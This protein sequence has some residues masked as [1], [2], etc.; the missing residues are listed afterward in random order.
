MKYTSTILF[1]G[2]GLMDCAI[3]AS[4]GRIVTAVEWDNKVAE[5]YAYNF[6]EVRLLVQSVQS[7]NRSELEPTDHIHLSPPCTEASIA[8]PT[9]RETDASIS[10]ARASL[11][12][13]RSIY[14]LGLWTKRA[15]A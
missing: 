3:A 15:F 9:A 11:E 10:A 13:I 8:N 7:V 6:P 5:Q 4:G 12:I 2:A 14:R 1:A